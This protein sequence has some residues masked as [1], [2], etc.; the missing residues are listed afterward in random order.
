MS[1]LVHVPQQKG[2]T[3]GEKPEQWGDWE[4]LHLDSTLALTN[5]HN[6][7]GIDRCFPMQL[8]EEEQ[9]PEVKRIPITTA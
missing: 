8:P 1:P 6:P 9:E 4:R 3:A 2:S 7:S 5:C